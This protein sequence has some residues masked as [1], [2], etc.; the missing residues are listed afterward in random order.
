MYKKVN[1]NCSQIVNVHILTLLCIKTKVFLT[2]VSLNTVVLDIC[3]Y[4]VNYTS[5]W[6]E[7]QVEKFYPFPSGQLVFCHRNFLH[8]L[9]QCK[10]EKLRAIITSFIYFY[11]L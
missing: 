3:Q 5:Q 1:S 11:P 6:N 10:L 7:W 9:F 4:D 8:L 2:V